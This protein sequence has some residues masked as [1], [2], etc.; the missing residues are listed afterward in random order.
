MFGGRTHVH[1]RV[2][3]GSKRCRQ[4]L[5]LRVSRQHGSA[6]HYARYSHFATTRAA[7]IGAVFLV[8]GV[9]HCLRD[10]AQLGSMSRHMLWMPI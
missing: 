7:H 3:Q 1:M 9:E 8:D 2:M 6:Q 10:F 5:C 4:R